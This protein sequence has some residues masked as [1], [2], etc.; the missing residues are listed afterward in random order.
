LV[1]RP[2][3]ALG[4]KS[5]TLLQLAQQQNM[6]KRWDDFSLGGE[7][8]K[9][10]GVEAECPYPKGCSQLYT[11]IGSKGLPNLNFQKIVVHSYCLPSSQDGKRLWLQNEK[12]WFL[13]SQTESQKL[14][15]ELLKEGRAK[16]FFE[17]EATADPQA[18]LWDELKEWIKNDKNERN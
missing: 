16:P 12:L 10:V 18:K 13:P 17:D 14:F 7:E 11:P 8:L 3:K 4:A 6:L 5:S 1:I 9:I 2:S 15:A